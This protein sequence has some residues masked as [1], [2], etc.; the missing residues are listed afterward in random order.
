MFLFGRK[1]NQELLAFKNWIEWAYARYEKNPKLHIYHY[2]HYEPSTLKRL[3]CRYGVGEFQVDNL[4]GNDVFVDLYRVVKQGLVVG[5]YSYSLKEIEKLYYP[6]RKTEVQSGGDSAVQF[7][8]FLNS[9]DQAETFKTEQGLSNENQKNSLSKKE[10]ETDQTNDK[11]KAKNTLSHNKQKTGQTLSNHESYSPFLKQIEDYNKDDCLSTYKLCQFLWDLQKKE[12]LSYRIKKEKTPED[13]EPKKDEKLSCQ[14][15]ARELLSH[16]PLEKRGLKLKDNEAHFYVAELLASLLEFHIR[17][18]KPSWWRYFEYFKTDEFEKLEDRNIISSGHLVKDE[19]NEYEIHFESDQEFDF[20]R[21]DKVAILENDKPF[22]F[23]QITELDLINSS[24]CLKPPKKSSP[25][26]KTGFSLVGTQLNVYKKN[27]FKSLLKTANEF[28]PDAI[29]F[30]LNKAIHDLL[31]KAP[32]DLPDHEGSLVR[33][34]KSLISDVSKHVLNLRDS[35]LCIQGPPGSGKT[36]TASHIILNLIKKGK[37]VGVTSNSHKAIL[38]LLKVLCEQ[39]KNNISFVCEK[40]CQSSKKGEE[41]KFIGNLPIELVAKASQTAQVVGATTYF[42]SRDTEE[43]SYDYLFI[44]EAS[45]V[46]LANTVAAGRSAK[47]IILLGDQNQLDQPIQASHPGESGQSALSY[48]T[49]GQGTIPEDRG[50]FLPTSYRL[51]PEICRFIS[52]HFYDGNLTPDPDNKNQKIILPANLKGKLP[53]KGVCF[54]PVDHS[55][56]REAS[57]EEVEVLSELYD[58]LLKASWQDKN[59]DISPLTAKDILIVAPYNL[60]VSYIKKKIKHPGLRVASV[61][62]FQGQEAPISILSLSSSSLQE[63]ARGIDFLFNKN[64]LNVSLSRA[65]ALAIVIGSKNLL[66]TR[67]KTIAHIELMNT[68]CQITK[69]N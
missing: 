9:K 29:Y 12:G 7:F 62:K 45:Q 28:S 31:L 17:E 6:K 39:N 59:N 63:S 19:D 35:V 25:L 49:D 41:E 26:P 20:Q 4:L 55:G 48:Y 15:K 64:R 27:L 11:L 66:D 2:G 47:N 37:R 68:F 69:Q 54:I 3:M 10:H 60:Q 13:K 67:L 34:K 16:I 22:E 8:H 61:D 18:D 43:N 58:K 65:K 24:L 21:G 14:K 57:W 50:V 30:G 23:Y 38:N 46:S 33:G 53:D 32:P 5:L 56:N 1:T 42:F 36:W 44:D 51:Q 40:I 52:D